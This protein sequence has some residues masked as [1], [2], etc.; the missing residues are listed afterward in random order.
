M[1]NHHA[2][3]LDL[4]TILSVFFELVLDHE[5]LIDDDISSLLILHEVGEIQVLRVV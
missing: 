4:L 2:W 3:L 1:S 5:I